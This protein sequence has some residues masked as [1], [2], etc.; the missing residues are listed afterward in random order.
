[1]NTQMNDYDLFELA[2]ENMRLRAEL[3]NYHLKEYHSSFD[4]TFK[5]NVRTFFGRKCVLCGVSES[6]LDN[7]LSVHHVEY[8]VFKSCY[9]TPQVPLCPGCHRLP[10]NHISERPY[11]IELFNNIINTQYGGK[12]CYTKG[13]YNLLV[14][15]DPKIKTHIE[16]YMGLKLGK[17]VSEPALINFIRAQLS[18][19]KD[20]HIPQIVSKI[21]KTV[22][23]MVHG[24][25]LTVENDKGK[26]FIRKVISPSV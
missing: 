6:E 22:G 4:L 7:K 25:L 2:N 14:N 13:E 9:E 23:S 12:W 19:K 20:S 16:S 11:W 18:R 24:G 15:A 8:E 21:K 10:H 3:E 5:E 17:R 26:K 1:M